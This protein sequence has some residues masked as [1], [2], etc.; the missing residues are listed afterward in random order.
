MAAS[1]TASLIVGWA[2]QVRARSSEEPPNSIST[3]RFVDHLAGPGRDNVHTQHAVGFLIGEHL[4]KPVGCAVGAGTAIGGEREFA[5][6]IGD[7]G[8]FSS[9]SVLPTVATSG[10]V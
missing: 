3:D 2:W 9:S 4:H 7:A 6:I 10:Q 1:F 8:A 5:N